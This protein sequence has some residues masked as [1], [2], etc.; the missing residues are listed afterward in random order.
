MLESLIAGSCTSTSQSGLAWWNH[1]FLGLLHHLIVHSVWS[2]LVEALILYFF[3]D[4][5]DVKVTLG[6]V[7]SN[8]CVDMFNFLPWPGVNRAMVIWPPIQ[9]LTD[10]LTI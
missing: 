7:E 6:G 8:F 5:H 3:L 4:I 10:L 2:F 1:L 9:D